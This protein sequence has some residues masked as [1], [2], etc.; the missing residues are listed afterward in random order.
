MLQESNTAVVARGE[1]W[2]GEATTEPYET[3]WARE[4]IF[5]LRALKVEGDLGG[6]KAKV[7]ISADGFHWADEGSSLALPATP[8][9]V[10]FCRISHFGGFLRLAVTVPDGAHIQVV[11]ALNLKA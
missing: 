11:A 1:H 5:F 2:R 10:V 6:V 8:G 4:A 7:Q 9:E 3:A